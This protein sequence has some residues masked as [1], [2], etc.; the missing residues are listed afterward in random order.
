MGRDAAL[1]TEVM[2]P[3]HQLLEAHLAGQDVNHCNAYG[4]TG[5]LTLKLKLSDLL[6]QNT[7]DSIVQTESQNVDLNPLDTI[8]T[9][10]MWSDGGNSWDIGLDHSIPSGAEHDQAFDMIASDESPGLGLIDEQ[11]PDQHTYRTAETSTSPPVTPEHPSLDQKPGCSA[12]LIG[13]SNESDPFSLQGFPYNHADEVDFFRVTYRKMSSSS[14]TTEFPGGPTHFLQSHEQTAS[15]ARSILEKCMSSNDDRETLKKLVDENM[16]VA[17]V[18]LQV[19]LPLIHP[20]RW[21][22]NQ[23][24]YFKFVYE[25]LPILSRSLVIGDEQDFIKTASTGLL[26]GIYALALPFT[27]WDEMFCLNSAYS[28]PDLD[29]LWQISYTCLQKELQFPRL[30]T[31]QIFLLLLNHV[32]FDPATIERPFM[33]TLAA[34]MLAM[35]QSLGLNT[36]PKGWKIPP[37]EIRL[38]RRLWWAVVVEHTWRSVTHGRSSMLCVDDWDV[39]PLT[40]DDFV[41]DGEPSDESQHSPDYFIHLCSLTE[42]TGGICR[43]F[44]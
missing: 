13:F 44:L 38:R 28:K 8:I 1:F 33:W 2:D 23:T 27:P 10:A 30:S 15:E 7:S 5:M 29:A 41:V 3:S 22:A 6:S 35:A 4:M 39:S 18:K 32:P 31:I 34:S 24:S 12:S 26:A 16:G 36:D 17:L 25:S 42:I 37:W 43:Q 14:K 19:T 20:R 11:T 21:M 9:D 40:T